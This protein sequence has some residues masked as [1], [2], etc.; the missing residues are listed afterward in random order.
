MCIDPLSPNFIA[1]YLK[2]RKT[3]HDAR[4]NGSNIDWGWHS[5]F[6]QKWP[7]WAISDRLNMMQPP[8]KNVLDKLWS[9]NQ[10]TFHMDEKIANA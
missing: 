7:E 6:L 2:F 1:K 4:P 3:Y 9:A 8:T 10:A 5:C